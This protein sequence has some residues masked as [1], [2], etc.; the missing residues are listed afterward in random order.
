MYRN[1]NRAKNL[2]YREWLKI[3]DSELKQIRKRIGIPLDGFKSYKEQ[4]EW[5][6]VQASKVVD[7]CDVSS[8]RKFTTE[9]RVEIDKRIED[10]PF[11]RLNNEIRALKEKYPKLSGYEKA[12]EQLV[13]GVLKTGAVAA[14]NYT[15]CSLA[16]ADEDKPINEPG[17]YIRISRHTLKS[18]IL[19]YV[20]ELEFDGFFEDIK[21]RAYGG[22]LEAYQHSPNILRDSIILHLNESTRDELNDFCTKRDSDSTPSPR[23]EQALKRALK[24]LGFDATEDAIQKVILR[25]RH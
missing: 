14:G 24:Y 20:S 2:W 6:S 8:G 3:P 13:L 7:M 9:E 17:L 19:D 23:K 15:G 21:K 25:N 22:K 1:K 16:F 10:T 5:Q 4:K 11:A 18:D 12:L